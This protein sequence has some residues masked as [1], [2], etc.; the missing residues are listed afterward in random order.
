MKLKGI[1]A[2]AVSMV[3]CV[4]SLF[5]GM[6]ATAAETVTYSFEINTT[7]AIAGLSGTVFYPSE[8]LSVNNVTVI[9]GGYA[10]TNQSGK[11][12]FNST[13]AQHPYSF[14]PAANVVTVTFNVN[15]DYDKTAV[16]STMKSIYTTGLAASGNVPFLYRNLIDGTKV[17]SGKTDIDHPEN[18]Y[19]GT[20]FEVNY[21]YSV[22]PDESKSVKKTVYTEE[23]A[24]KT[25]AEL[26]MPSFENP[27]YTYS[28]GR[29]DRSGA[30]TLSTTLVATAKKYEV[31]VNGEL[32]G[33]YGYM[34][35]A[36]LSYDEEKSFVIDG[37]VVATGKSFSFFVTG[38]IAVTVEDP[39]SET[40]ENATLL[41]NARYI[42]D[43]GG[44]TYVR[45]ELLATANC[46]DFA[47]MGVALALSEKTYTEISSA[48]T[49]ISSGSGVS[50]KIHVHN[51]S[52]DYP[53]MSGQY[54]FIYAPYTAIS[55]IPAG[56]TMYYYAYSVNQ[57]GEVI[58]SP[59]VE[60][61]LSNIKA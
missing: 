22:T 27:Y 15:N 17:T 37:N 50:S 40:D 55:K 41:K 4:T 8:S 18:D 59:A 47:R 13:N 11:I 52:V 42:Y 2:L 20:A 61:N 54:Q 35:T 14:S 46:K 29:V 26:G 36:A 28:V 44:E 49:T 12:L 19:S 58:V 3:I 7:E 9:G 24:D 43:E 53:N 34:G 21:T 60:V 32:K 16:Y 39:S 5:G 30:T 51:S 6:T 57:N 48:V 31:T 23:T 45:L 33:E 25:I 56:R 10:N 1:I 38:D